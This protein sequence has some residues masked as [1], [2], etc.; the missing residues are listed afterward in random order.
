MSREGRKGYSK[1]LRETEVK[2][3]KH[4]KTGNENRTQP[5]KLI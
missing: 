2:I 3:P 4:N 5:C 1:K